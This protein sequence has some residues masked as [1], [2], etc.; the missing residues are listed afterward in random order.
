MQADGT[1]REAYSIPEVCLR[2]GLGRSSIYEEIKAKRLRS[3]T[4]GRRRLVRPSALR[5]WLIVC[6]R[7][8]AT[9]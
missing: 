3:F 8:G 9:R 6:E 4:V 5:E 2:T 7:K 1:E